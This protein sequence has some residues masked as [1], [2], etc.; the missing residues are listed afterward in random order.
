M[1]GKQ[2]L[3]TGVI[4]V[5]AISLNAC[6]PTELQHERVDAASVRK[7]REAVE[8][9]GCGACHALPGIAWPSGRVGPSLHGFANRAM[10][11]G[12][13]PNR[14]DI[15]ARFV[16]DA[17]ALVPG[18]AMPEIEMTLEEADAIT[19]WLQSLDES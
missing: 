3:R 5:I 4:G 2:M 18:T 8:R 7:G 19:A 14:P 10:I 13:L 12:Q 1:S 6:S 16:R 9:L 11:A 17:P 15:L